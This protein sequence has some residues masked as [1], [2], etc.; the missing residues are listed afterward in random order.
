VSVTIVPPVVGCAVFELI[1]AD[2]ISWVA[3]VPITSVM[4]WILVGGVEVGMVMELPIEFIWP[5]PWMEV[6]IGIVVE[7][8]VVTPLPL[9]VVKTGRFV[10]RVDV[11]GDNP[12]IERS[13]TAK[14][15][16]RRSPGTRL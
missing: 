9:T 4:V 5:E 1:V 11:P 7:P 13:T 14:Y 15:F 2:T 10:A 6:E 16:L 12:T 3:P 8:A